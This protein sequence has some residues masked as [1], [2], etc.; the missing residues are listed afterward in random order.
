MHS[1]RPWNSSTLF[2]FSIMAVVVLALM[3]PIHNL[4]ISRHQGELPAVDNQPP[5]ASGETPQG[6][7]ANDW[8]LIQTAIEQAEYHFAR[9]QADATH[10]APYFW[11]PNRA[12]GWDLV[13]EGNGP[14]ISPRNSNLWQWGL[15]T[16]GYGYAGAMQSLDGRPELDSQK[17]T[18]T[19][20]WD[21]IL[22]EWWVNQ[23]S[24]LEHGFTLTSRP[25]VA[26]DTQLVIEMA[27]QGSL[28]P[29]QNGEALTFVDEGGQAILTYAGLQVSDAHGRELAARLELAYPQ[30]GSPALVRILVDDSQAL[31]PITVDPWVQSAKL[32][33]SDGSGRENIGQSVAISGDTVV[34]GAYYDAVEGDY[35]RGS[36]YIFEKPET[37][38][39][40]VPESAKL[41]A[42]DGEPSDYFGGAVDIDGDTVVVGAYGVGDYEGAAYIF[43][44]PLAGWATV[45]SETAR[46]SWSSGSTNDRFGYAIAIS[47]DTV[48]VGAYGE[49]YDDSGAAHIYVK[50]AEGWHTTGT[51]DAQLYS[52]AVDNL[53][54]SVDLYE[55]T[56]VIGAPK[57]DDNKGAAYIYEKPETGWETTY[58]YTAKLTASDGILYDRLGRAVS[59]CEDTILV[60]AYGDDDGTGSAYIFE[61]PLSGGWVTTDVFNAKLTASDGSMEDGFG[62]AV[63]I[64]GNTLVVGALW[65]NDQAGS[66]YVFQKPV[67]GWVSGSETAKLTAS[68][69]AAEDDFGITVAISGDTVVIGAPLNY[70]DRGS[71]YLYTK[72]TGDWVTTTET[73]QLIGATSDGADWFGNSV[74]I[75]NETIVVGAYEDN[76]ERGAVYLFT[77]PGGGWTTATESAKLTA[78]DGA[79]GD[80]FGRSVAISGDTILIGMGPWDPRF[81]QG[82]AYLFEKPL[83]GWVSGSESA[84]LTASDG[85]SGDNFG[86]AVALSGDTAAMG[87]WGDDDVA[88]DAGAVYIFEKPGSQW[89]TSD[90]FTAK[91]TASDGSA[92]DE[93]GDTLSLDGDVLVVG[94]QYKNDKGAVYVFEKPFDG[95]ATG[96]ETAILTASDG[97]ES[98]EFGISVSISGDALAVG[99]DVNQSTGSVYVFER[100]PGGWA[101]GNESAKLRVIENDSGTFG[102]RVCIHADRI[103]AEMS[104]YPDPNAVYLF[105][106]PEGGW[107]S[108]SDYAARLRADDSVYGDGFGT[109]LDMSS[110][111]LIAG[112]SGYNGKQGAA[113]V[114]ELKTFTYL[115]LPLVV[116]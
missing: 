114:F 93:F 66:A 115:Y 107:V 96:N 65:D 116:R 8:A 46:L 24:G 33:A 111:T 19:Y 79:A 23:D 67:S 25:A 34:V 56:A 22:S 55:D 72:P 14:M 58:M 98:D 103:A 7:T 87:A 40:S 106:K 83:S 92:Y 105:E 3:L 89:A 16:R 4:N 99:A 9:H 78:S 41:A 110:D 54:W 35:G 57:H 100:P 61:K 31:Y 86:W 6:L 45:I 13:F 64:D 76:D 60:G 29:I 91:L 71:A 104:Q 47:G 21:E 2:T 113:Y 10:K 77:L 48:V 50:P 44:K 102:Y 109:A 38:W 39:G 30:T 85:E 90:A 17:D 20:R 62:F 26:Q 68:N 74:A 51:S 112:A 42:S 80:R 73:V 53:G 84:I 82:K 12:Q 5:T 75:E 88:D 1:S 49:G 95:W 108:T 18:L 70:N 97:A 43:E 36:V 28:A 52:G 32:T 11:A 37:G 94:L 59:I 69:G 15:T 101:T 63:A 27:V 81:N